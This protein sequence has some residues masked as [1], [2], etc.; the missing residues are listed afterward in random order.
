MNARCNLQSSAPIY[1]Y[2]GEIQLLLCKRCTLSIF[3]KIVPKITTS[4]AT[5]LAPTHISSACYDPT[6]LEASVYHKL[7]FVY[8][9]LCED[10]SQ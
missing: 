8:D 9:Y 6:C 7:E 4:N 5:Y 3:I 10:Q 1:G 2:S